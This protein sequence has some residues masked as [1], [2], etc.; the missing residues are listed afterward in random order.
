MKKLILIINLFA[1][2]LLFSQEGY[3][4]D[5]SSYNDINRIDG[6]RT[7]FGYFDMDIDTYKK[8]DMKYG[9]YEIYINFRKVEENY[10]IGVITFYL[11]KK[12]SKIEFDSV[13]SDSEKLEFYY[14]GIRF[15]TYSTTD[16]IFIEYP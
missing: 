2:V 1:S 13:I 15:A 6:Y 5:F 3:K 11:G 4:I 16:K 8:T 14:H 7:Y 12:S 9:N 10:G